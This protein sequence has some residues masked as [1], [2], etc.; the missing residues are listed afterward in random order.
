MKNKLKLYW[1]MPIR[2]ILF[3]MFFMITSYCS[4]QELPALTKWWS[5]V[6][7]V[8]NIVMIL[9]FVI[10]VQKKKTNYRELIM[11]K[12]ETKLSKILIISFMMILIGMGGMYMAGFVCYGQFPYLAPMMIAPIP[13][14]LSIFSIIVLPI[15]TT[16]VEDGLYLGCGVNQI[17]TKWLAIVIPA[18]FY[19]LQHS[20]IPTLFDG[21]F[22]I[23]RF[24]SFLPLTLMICYWYYYKRNPLPIMIGHTIL[25]LATVTQIF[26]MS[27]KPELYYQILNI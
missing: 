23:Y 8:V 17:K 18:F 1:L 4:N 6:A 13:V 15:T 27:L 11:Y 9:I 21:Q 25:N 3:L 10:I 24:L 2:S 19:A 12:K 22:I 14:F 7:C 20:F 26:I 16:L 5:I